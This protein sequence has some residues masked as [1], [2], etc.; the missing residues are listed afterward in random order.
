MPSH[1]EEERKKRR[2]E[3]AD[4]DEFKRELNIEQSPVQ[5]GI[6]ARLRA[7]RAGQRGPGNVV[8]S[9]RQLEQLEAG[10]AET[11]KQLTA[12]AQRRKE[13]KARKA[14]LGR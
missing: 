3:R 1:T 9:V 12:D 2:E 8:G 10:Q 7:A 13:A 5:M 14:L 6:I 11:Q 4:L